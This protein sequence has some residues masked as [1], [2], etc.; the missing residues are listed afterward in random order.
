[1]D[2]A[3]TSLLA[4]SVAFVGAHFAMSHPLRDPMVRLF[5]EKGFLGVYS[6]VILA[7]FAWMVIAFR[8]APR[9]GMPVWSGQDDVSW[10]IASGLTIIALVLFLGALRGNPALPDIPAEKV[11]ASEPRGVFLVTRHPMMWGFAL[12]AIAHLLVAPTGRTLILAGSILIL[13]LLGAHL[14]DRKKEALLGQAWKGWSSRTSYWPRWRKLHK[15]GSTL[16]LVA[17]VIWLAV[18][19]AHI[20]FGY[21]AAGIWRWIG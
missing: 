10:A 7:T 14:Q 18:T 20:W 8:A 15:A 9:R 17:I 11:A 5:G 19:W 21:V 1:M 4:A 6:L 12:W 16:W 2:P 13:A 3:L